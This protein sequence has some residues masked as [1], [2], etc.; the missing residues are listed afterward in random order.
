MAAPD[1]QMGSMVALGLL[2]VGV[3][4]ASAALVARDHAGGPSTDPTNGY[5]AL[6]LPD[7]SDATLVNYSATVFVGRVVRVSRVEHLP[8]SN[9][10]STIPVTYYEVSAEQTLKGIAIGQIT[11]R[12]F[13]GE[14]RYMEGD[15]PLDQGKSYLF[16]T[17]AFIPDIGA[18]SIAIPGYGNIPISSDEQRTELIERF[19]VLIDATLPASTAEAQ[20]TSVT[21]QPTVTSTAPTIN[22]VPT[23]TSIPTV[24]GPSPTVPEPT[25][26]ETAVPSSTAS[27]VPAATEPVPLVVETPMSAG[28]PST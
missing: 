20:E 17:T 24:L 15:G 5:G 4:I 23:E 3:M 7:T 14:D 10:D 16:L 21:N 9:P 12:Q 19:A 28:G 6:G 27:L 2:V 11:V 1:R 18:Y 25:P 8:T 26:T 22:D 13:G